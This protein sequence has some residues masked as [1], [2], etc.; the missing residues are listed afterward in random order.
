MAQQG[1]RV[2]Q[3]HKVRMEMETKRLSAMPTQVGDA[4]S[5]YRL[6]KRG[7]WRS[8]RK[9]G[10]VVEVVDSLIADCKSILEAHLSARRLP[11]NVKQVFR[12]AIHA[13]L[14]KLTFAGFGDRVPFKYTGRKK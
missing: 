5:A 7:R 12:N 8:Q 11:G 1:K 3:R 14:N 6:A 13:R 4:R 2:S 10:E 9:A